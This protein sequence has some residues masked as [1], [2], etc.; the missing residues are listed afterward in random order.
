MRTVKADIKLG[1]IAKVI[2]LGD[3]IAA[4][5][6]N[7]ISLVAPVAEAS[8]TNETKCMSSFVLPED[9]WIGDFI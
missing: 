6:S 7:G 1:N 3:G 5:T 8:F 4:I 9:I 2:S